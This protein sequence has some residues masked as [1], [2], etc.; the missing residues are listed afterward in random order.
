M[1]CYVVKKPNN[2]PQNAQIVPRD[3]LATCVRVDP[4]SGKIR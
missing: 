1:H 2:D 4:I 3:E